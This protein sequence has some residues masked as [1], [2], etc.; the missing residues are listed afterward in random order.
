MEG[1]EEQL[2]LSRQYLRYWVAH[3]FPETRLAA[4]GTHTTP[5]GREFLLFRESSN[6]LH[7]VAL[8]PERDC[9]V[10]IGLHGGARDL[11]RYRGSLLAVLDSYRVK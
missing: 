7:L 9:V 3:G 10:E 8:A 5:G 4:D 2:A 1:S 11:E 6:G